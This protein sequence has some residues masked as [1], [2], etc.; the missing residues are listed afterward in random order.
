VRLSGRARYGPGVATA[1]AAGGLLALAGCGG[2]DEKEASQT[3]REFVA[4]LNARDADKF[5]GELVTEE[6]LER[7]TFAEGDKAREECERTLRQ[8]RGLKLRLVR[9]AGVKV[10][11]DRA[12]VRAVLSYQRQEQDQLYRLR[13]EDGDWRLASGSGG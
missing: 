13:K 7:Q 11:G 6:Y 12:R 1:L 8:I 9:I 4:A 2:D 10:D 3:V 5:C